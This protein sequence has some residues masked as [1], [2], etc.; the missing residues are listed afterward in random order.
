MLFTLTGRNAGFV[1]VCVSQAWAAALPW[2]TEKIF[3][4]V[5]SQKGRAKNPAF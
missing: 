2:V 4:V 3:N 5:L 1:S